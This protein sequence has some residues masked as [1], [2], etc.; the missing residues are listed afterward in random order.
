MNIAS[1]IR[2]MVVMLTVCLISQPIFAQNVFWSEDFGGG[3]IPTGWTNVEPNDSTLLWEYETDSAR[4]T[5]AFGGVAFQS[6]TVANGFVM[7]DSDG[8]GQLATPHDTRLSTSLIDCSTQPTVFVRFENQFVQYAASTAELGVSTDGTTWTYFPLFAGAATGNS[9]VSVTNQ[10]EEIDISAVAGSQATVYLQFRWQGNF[11]YS[12][13][14]DDIALQDAATLVASSNNLALGDFFFVVDNYATPASQ[15][16]SDT[17]DSFE[18]DVSNIGDFDQTNVIVTAE[19]LDGATLQTV[20]YMDTLHIDNLPVGYL[21][22]S[23]L[24]DGFFVPNQLPLIGDYAVVYSITSD[25]VDV[26]MADNVVGE[27]FEITDSTFSKDAGA[28][29]AYQPNGGGDHMTGNVYTTDENFVA[30]DFLATTAEFAA[31]SNGTLD[32]ADV[33]VWL[34]EVSS[35]IDA[36]YSNFDGTADLN[37][38]ADLT[39]V[40]FASHTFPAGTAN[41]DLQTVALQDLSTG[42]AGVSLKPGTRYFLLVD[43]S[44]PANVHFQAYSETINFFQVST[45]LY[46]TGWFLGGFGSEITAVARMNIG[47]PAVDTV[48]TNQVELKNATLNVFPNPAQAYATVDLTLENPTDAILTISDVTGRVVYYENLNN[49]SNE[50]LTLDVSQYAAGTYFVKV[51]TTEGIKTQRL[52]VTH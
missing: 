1:T 16:A 38:N 18:V 5:V 45:V 35:N 21:D 31:A 4:V 50:R 9:G 39:V 44:G 34:A 2:L 37:N 29:T 42:E 12:W 26:D 52:I 15:I 24:F 27:F 36:A 46:T 28:T 17:F 41:F 43:Y 25:S 11:E 30:G 23:A 6:T 47:V 10:T 13:K 7:F 20:Y 32:G 48:S 22:S 40:G 33:T 14:L 51:T 3:V 8:Y 19:I 49:V